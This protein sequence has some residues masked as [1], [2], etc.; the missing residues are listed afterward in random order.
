LA[1]QQWGNQLADLERRLQGGI[2]I[3]S[4]G[5]QFHFDGLTREEFQM[6]GGTAIP[7]QQQ[8]PTTAQ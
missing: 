3:W 1:P 2:G 8:F 6:P 7:K 5:D 4:H